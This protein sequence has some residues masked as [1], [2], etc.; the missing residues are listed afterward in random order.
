MDY[1]AII[2]RAWDVTWKNRALWL[3]GFLVGGA[4]TNWIYQLS[5][6]GSDSPAAFR[7]DIFKGAESIGSAAPLN[8][9]S[10]PLGALI[11]IL[12]GFILFVIVMAIVSAVARGALIGL[13]RRADMGE[14]VTIRAGFS[15]GLKNFLAIIGISLAIW[16][17]AIILGI[18]VPLAFLV[19]AFTAFAVSLNQENP[20]PALI[21]AVLL[22]LLLYAAVVLPIAIIL[23]LINI[24]AD[25]YRVVEG[26]GV[27]TSIS[28]GFRL[29]RERKG[30]SAA[31][32][33]IVLGLSL[34][35]AFAAGFIGL[36]TILTSSSI[37]SGK[38]LL[39]IMLAIPGLAIL[40][41]ASSVFQAFVSSTWTLAFLSMSGLGSSALVQ[42]TKGEP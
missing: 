29:L 41:L 9:P 19:P 24:Y 17:P 35:F 33:F 22:G 3:F 27:F 6:I 10:L 26:S 38:P 34:A 4:G 2:S 28:K 16:I 23:S 15:D 14:A 42:G 5:S 12:F 7:G 36:T 30:A 18:L 21:A 32:F 8:T 40:I 31:F 11:A 1:S 25:S 20:P 13:V 39:G 37:F